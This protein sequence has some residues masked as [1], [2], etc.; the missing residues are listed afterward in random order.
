MATKKIQTVPEKK[1]FSGLLLVKAKEQE[2]TPNDLLD[3]LGN[4]KDER[5]VFTLRPFTSTERYEV[6][7]VDEMVKAESFAWCKEKGID[8]ANLDTYQLLALNSFLKSKH[9]TARAEKVLRKCVLK[10]N[11][12]E[13]TDEIFERFHPK[14]SEDLFAEVKRISYLTEDDTINL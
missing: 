11:G 9:I 5:P 12:V 4:S 7:A 14:L 3:R 8:P 6:E 1:G 2:Y 10:F 13:L